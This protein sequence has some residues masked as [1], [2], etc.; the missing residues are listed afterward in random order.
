M[1]T[2]IEYLTQIETLIGLI[3]AVIIAGIV[4]YKRIR[5][6]WNARNELIKVAGDLI[7]QAEEAPYSLANSIAGLPTIIGD[8]SPDSNEGKRNI[9]AQALVEREPKLLKKLKISDAIGAAK[10]VN[11]IYP[12]FKPLIKVLKK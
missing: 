8:I 1:N 7:G 9:V 12:L 10:F 3:S 6:E 5:S 2:I 11:S 4:A